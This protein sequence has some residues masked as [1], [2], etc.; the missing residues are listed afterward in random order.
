M[1]QKIFII[2]TSGLILTL[3]GISLIFLSKSPDLGRLT[4][5]AQVLR[6]DSKEIIN[7]RLTSSGHWR[8]PAQ[9]ERIDP[10]LIKMLIAYEDKRF[11]HHHGVDPIAV[12][13]ATISLAKSGKIK[14]G[15]S[16]LTMQAV[17][18]MHP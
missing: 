15:A 11:W 10:Q 16:T 8:E 13:R 18:L 6:G 2:I 17:K 12:F 9:L 3:I 14:S 7:L 1:I 5:V 4:D